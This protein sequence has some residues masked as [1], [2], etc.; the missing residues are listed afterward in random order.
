MEG[1]VHKIGVALRDMTQVLLKT[2]NADRNCDFCLI[3]ASAGGVC[4]G[5]SLHTHTHMHISLAKYTK[6]INIV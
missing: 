6:Q 2:K 4:V 1:V 3:A 5:I